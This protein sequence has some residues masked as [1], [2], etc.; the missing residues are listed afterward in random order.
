MSSRNENNPIDYDL[1]MQIQNDKMSFQYQSIIH[2]QTGSDLLQGVLDS[3][4]TVSDNQVEITIDTN[5]IYES[6]GTVSNIS[7]LLGDSY[8]LVLPSRNTL[9]GNTSGVLVF[10]NQP[11]Y[12]EDHANLTSTDMFRQHS[13]TR[14]T[15]T[16]LKGEFTPLSSLGGGS[17]GDTAVGVGIIKAPNDANA[18]QQIVNATSQSP[19]TGDLYFNTTTDL[20]QTYYDHTDASDKWFPMAMGRIAGQPS[21]L[22][23]VTISNT[24]AFFDITWELPIQAITSMSSDISYTNKDSPAVM[25]N[26]VGQN[27]IAF[28]I[29]NRIIMKVQELDI[30]NNVIANL[31]YPMYSY[32]GNVQK[33][34]VD[35][36]GYVI[37]AKGNVIATGDTDESSRTSYESTTSP[38]RNELAN[39][40]TGIRLY[41]TTP[42]RTIR[43]SQA[44]NV[45]ST[46]IVPFSSDTVGTSL[47][48]PNERYKI[49]LWLE[50]NSNDT[51]VKFVEVIDSYK[52][53]P[54]PPVPEAVTLLLGQN[55]GARPSAGITQ[56]SIEVEDPEFVAGTNDEED[57]FLNFSEIKFE[58]SV[59]GFASASQFAKIRGPT[60]GS[61][62][63]VN[64]E[65]T[66][67]NGDLTVNRLVDTTARYY[68]FD[69]NEDYMGSD[70]T[71]IDFT[72]DSLNLAVRVSYKNASNTNYGQPT[73]SNV[74]ISYPEKPV[75]SSVVM[76]SATSFT[77]TLD[78]YSGIADVISSNITTVP[79]NSNYA[80]F[81]EALDLKAE[82]ELDDG[83]VVVY[84]GDDAIT[85]QDYY[86][87][88]DS[89]SGTSAGRQG[90]STT[91]TFNLPAGLPSGTTATDTYR[92]RFSVRVRN[93]LIDYW[94]DYS[95]FTGGSGT[96]DG[97]V[98]DGT[99]LQAVEIEGITG[100]NSFITLDYQNSGVFEDQLLI[101]WGHPT[102]NNRGITDSNKVAAGLPKVYDYQIALVSSLDSNQ[103][104]SFTITQTA[105]TND[106]PSTNAY[107]DMGTMLDNLGA[108]YSDPNDDNTVGSQET[109]DITLEQ[110]NEYISTANTITSV[111]YY[112]LRQP[113]AATFNSYSSTIASSQSSY[114]RLTFDW[115]KPAFQGLKVG[116]TSPLTNGDNETIAINRYVLTVEA[117]ATT[118]TS[119]Y[120]KNQVL[121]NGNTSKEIQITFD[122][123]NVRDDAAH[124]ISNI[125][126]NS[127]FSNAT[128][129]SVSEVFV[130]P[131]TIY[132]F[133]VYNR[134]R[135][136]LT[137]TIPLLY[138]SA[139]T[140]TPSAIYNQFNN[141]T[142]PI[143]N[144]YDDLSG[145]SS[146][147]SRGFLLNISNYDAS[148]AN[149]SNLVEITKESEINFSKQGSHR[150]NKSDFMDFLAPTTYV[151]DATAY[152]L[153]EFRLLDSGYGDSVI[154]TLGT[155]DDVTY[156]QFSTSDNVS[157]DLSGSAV[158][159]PVSNRDVYN[160][161]NYEVRNR[162]YWWYETM[163]FTI[164]LTGGFHSI[165]A[166]Q[167]GHKIDLEVRYNNKL[168]SVDYTG[169]NLSV[170]ADVD[171]YSRTI[172]RN[173]AN[174][175]DLIW[176][177]S[178]TGNPQREK[179]STEPYIREVDNTNKI[180]GVPNLYPIGSH[181]ITADSLGYEYQVNYNATNYS[182]L[183]GLTATEDFFSHSFIGISSSDVLKS[184]MEE[185]NWTSKTDCTRNNNHWNVEN[186]TIT[187]ADLG[188][189]TSTTLYKDIGL[190]T[191]L[192]N[193]VGTNQQ[194]LGVP[195]ESDSNLTYFIYDKNSVD[196]L[197]ND[198]KI[199][200]VP[201]GFEPQDTTYANT[202]VVTGRFGWIGGEVSNVSVDGLFVFDGKF[203]TESSTYGGFNDL[204]TVDG[205]NSINNPVAY[206]LTASIPKTP[207]DTYRWQTFK[208]T[209]TTASDGTLLNSF[210]NTLYF[211]FGGGS[212]ATSITIDDILATNTA[213]R[214]ARLFIQIETDGTTYQYTKSGFDNRKWVEYSGPNDPDNVDVATAFAGQ[215]SNQLYN[216]LS[217]G[218]DN[219]SSDATW[220]GTSY[221]PGPNASKPASSY[222]RTY[223]GVFNKQGPISTSFTVYLAIGLDKDESR[224][225][226]KPA[227]VK[228]IKSGTETSTQVEY[229]LS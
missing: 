107:L 15:A 36:D 125:Q 155:G 92:W 10:Q 133:T 59:N 11:N 120:Y 178:L 5:S 191:N 175:D 150:M 68:T 137:S 228:V 29:V 72:N 38:N 3:N 97:T 102:N 176:L 20:F 140:D 126:F 109:M 141:S 134:N 135:Y 93:N 106:P 192:R 213:D 8:S 184:D 148:A 145:V 67:S 151:T 132:S 47:N 164:D 46:F 211:P 128:G 157:N 222:N 103:S 7:N 50:N 181:P 189:L 179:R 9:I 4:S 204:F 200:N 229:T 180:N 105:R 218:Y 41:K 112:S 159:A 121:S 227:F 154:Q 1:N 24:T 144:T 174:T 74:S 26:T 79:T 119:P 35:T 16:V 139:R 129:D 85:S 76:N 22:S 75:I 195:S 116:T 17:G 170:N 202:T 143:N 117:N 210:V 127:S 32:S 70:Y 69:F 167:K 185:R 138:T 94:S 49:T 169:S 101:E 118:T 196:L 6:N 54:P 203:L 162:G 212:S 224:H 25:Q 81:T 165:S 48:L 45:S 80:V 19:Q 168:N 111:I 197:A 199:L 96:N 37:Y 31:T 53:A 21:P 73:E 18:T 43:N 63:Y 209:Q 177:D 57:E 194:L 223:W 82:Y 131:E 173:S 77:I 122:G 193:T 98:I 161:T 110:R 226:T 115:N 166:Y 42:S 56:M 12:H 62:N 23:N 34:T 104:D 78:A 114:N 207:T 27:I 30:S 83:T 225:F 2:S 90:A 44:A 147:N 206:G 14:R 146:Y 201:D 66:L 188:T 220:Q 88:N 84:E 124:I 40:P 58:W 130:Y 71:T 205:G 52:I 163:S 65:N 89:L 99:S 172:C 28:P 136:G 156:D 142:L 64:N 13:S 100:T 219:T 160:Q 183:W 86:Y 55:D 123:N 60:T 215:L 149:V 214:H 153:R 51:A 221:V 91:Y 152:K 39:M 186:V 217:L 95:D 190:Y 113:D 198:S 108:T 182:T 208:Y 158:L 33:S 171:V 187:Q 216:G 87:D 61:A